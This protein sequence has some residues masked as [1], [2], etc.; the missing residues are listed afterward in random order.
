MSKNDLLDER[1]LPIVEACAPLRVVV[2]LK[3]T[4]DR[5]YIHFD[6]SKTYPEPDGWDRYWM[7]FEPY[8][9]H[10]LKSNGFDDSSVKL[11][12]TYH[13]VAFVGTLFGFL[14]HE[15]KGDE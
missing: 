7:G 12:D 11:K 14:I 9:K 15:R 10:L 6:G 13:A 3:R 2:K 8:V 5:Y 1:I 4:K